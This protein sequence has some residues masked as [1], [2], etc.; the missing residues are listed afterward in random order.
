VKIRVA[1]EKGG[2]VLVRLRPREVRKK[3]VVLD[4][5]LYTVSVSSLQRLHD[6]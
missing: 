4:K 5:S 3:G 2:D 1:G 6:N